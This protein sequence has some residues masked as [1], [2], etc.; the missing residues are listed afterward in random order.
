MTDIDICNQALGWL[1]AKRIAAFDDAS[2]E[3]QL[4]SDNFVPLRDAVLEDRAWTFAD[5]SIVLDNAVPGG[6]D[7]GDFLYALP[8]DV[9]R[10]YRVFRRVDLTQPTQLEGWRREGSNVAARYQAKIYIKATIQIEDVEE[11]TAAF[12][13]ALA[14]RLA[15]DLAMPITRSR[16]MQEDMWKL[17]EKKLIMA[18]A[19][20]AGQG[21]SE[22]TDST[23]LV[24]VRWAD[25]LH[26]RVGGG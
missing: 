7:N 17:Y 1:G 15:A 21:R 18:A 14:A 12:T 22:R 25:G 23:E 19:T 16:K 2:N 6:W 4:C 24:G 11:F 8:P 26:G 10:V 5:S 13:Q 20:D 3:A 9:L